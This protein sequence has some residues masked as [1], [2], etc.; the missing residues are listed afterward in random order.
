M[1]YLHIH[2]TIDL[3]FIT[4]NEIRTERQHSISRRYHRRIEPASG[5]VSLQ[6]IIIN[7]FSNYC[8]V[9]RAISV[10]NSVLCHPAEAMK[11]GKLYIVRGAHSY[12]TCT[13]KSM[14]YITN[15]R[16]REGGA[17][18]RSV[19][20]FILNASCTAAKHDCMT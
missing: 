20:T 4:E 9:Y 8:I 12:G 7:T 11:A 6:S 1:E 14:I 15:G 3:L 13:V 2:K 17:V 18:L 10:D 19:F 5:H 16:E